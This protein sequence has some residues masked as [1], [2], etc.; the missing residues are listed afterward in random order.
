VAVLGKVRLRRHLFGRQAS[1]G[2]AVPAVRA[3]PFNGTPTPNLN[4][5]ESEY[6]AGSLYPV[7][8]RSKGIPDLNFTLNAP[9]LSY[10]DLPLMFASFFGNAETPT[11]TG[12]AQA[13]DWTPDGLGT[14]DFDAFCYEFG[15]DADGTSGKPNDWEQYID[16]IATSVTID[17]PEQGGGVLNA[18]LG[19]KFSDLKYA[20]ST[21]IA[22]V[23]TIPSITDRPDTQPVRVYAKDC[24]VYLDTDASDIGGTQLM[25]TVH[26][27]NLA[28]T[29][30][31]DEKRWADGTQS[32]AVEEYG[33]G[34]TRINL[35]VTGAKSDDWV[36]VG[37]ESDAWSADEQIA[38]YYR[39][40][41]EA[42]VDADPGTPYSW[43]FS[44]PARYFQREHGE[45]GNN[46]V[47]ILTAEAF[48]DETLDY[49]FSTQV[50]NTL[51]SADL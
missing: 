44:M 14:E 31:V 47:I 2:T 12:D 11:P 15:D 41:F 18:S 16:G 37:S 42:T 5:I 23:T 48:L 21:D 33:R 35:A 13:W 1:I 43:E 45:I 24:S 51:A 28:L 38:R 32:F 6:D 3:Y 29:Q 10:N 25:S 26:K 40:V 39:F 22:P 7:V 19:L 17:S 27:F 49:P 46:S 20:G 8:P 34:A 4:W 30:E 9:T 36:G 50:V